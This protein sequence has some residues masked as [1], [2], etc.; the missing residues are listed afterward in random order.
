MLDNSTEQCTNNNV[1]LVAGASL[2]E[3]RVEVCHNGV[4]GTV[5]DDRWDSYDA[6]VVC[7]QLGI[8]FRGKM[9]HLGIFF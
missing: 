6:A 7:R 4:W 1:R 3:G 5:C 8:P 2:S 9:I